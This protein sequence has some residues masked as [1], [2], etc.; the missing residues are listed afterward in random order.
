MRKVTLLHL[1]VRPFT[2][3]NRVGSWGSG[4]MARGAI[5]SP[6]PYP[7]QPLPH[8]AT[9]FP[10]PHLYRPHPP[11]PPHTYLSTP[12][13]SPIYLPPHSWPSHQHLP[14]QYPS[15][16]LLPRVFPSPNPLLDLSSRRLG[17][18]RFSRKPSFRHICFNGQ[19]VNIFLKMDWK[20]YLEKYNRWRQM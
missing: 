6:T 8:K 18:K 15:N 1:S 7:H 20:H 13:M 10:C 12:S 4:R 19:F 14:T 11:T 5:V 2:R 16:P 3:G 17:H 9:L